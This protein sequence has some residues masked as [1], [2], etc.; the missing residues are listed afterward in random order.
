MGVISH[1]ARRVKAM[2][3]WHLI[4]LADLVSAGAMHVIEHLKLNCNVGPACVR[5]YARQGMLA[6]LR[7]WDHGSKEY[8]VNADRF[9]EYDESKSVLGLRRS[10]PPPPIEL[11]I[12]L[13]RELLKL[14]LADAL[15]WTSRRLCD[16]D[17]DVS[18]RELREAA[19]SQKN[20]VARAANALQQALREYEPRP[21]KTP[22][23]RAVELFRRG[24]S[25]AEVAKVLH[26]GQDKAAQ[27][28]DSIDPLAKRRRAAQARAIRVGR[29]DVKTADIIQLRRA[30]Y[31][32]D[33]IANELGCGQ[34]LVSK[35]LEKLGL[36]EGRID[37]LRKR[38]IRPLA[39]CGSLAERP[40]A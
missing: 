38:G 37:S 13:L 6:E 29:T 36:R 31:T 23:Q 16:N 9:R 27:I 26:I 1:E 35:R 18:A 8:P 4:E 33:A 20:R 24:A 14:R 28:Q 22:R 32:Q 21:P 7:R 34:H 2:L 40:R 11:M 3:P 12:D 39:K 10:E 17:L 25:C 19:C 5:V 15:A 30:G